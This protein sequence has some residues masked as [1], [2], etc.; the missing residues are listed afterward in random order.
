MQMISSKYTFFYKYILIIIWIVG[1][2]FGAREVIFSQPIFSTQWT[3]YVV[4]WAAIALFIFFAT[5]SIK[6]VSLQSRKKQFQVSNFLKT[7][8][9][10]F[11]EI[12]DIDGSSMLSPKLVWFVLKKESIFGRKISFMPKNRP[13]RGIGKHP[14]VMELRKEFNLDR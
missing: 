10:D 7:I 2:G 11:A 6:M 8:T 5:G 14:I 4:C 1:F 9:V 3:Q 12:E 13:T